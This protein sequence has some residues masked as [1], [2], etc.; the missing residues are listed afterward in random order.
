[1]FNHL[2]EI[3]AL[4]LTPGDVHDGAP[5]EQLTQDPTGK[6]FSDKGYF[7]K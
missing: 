6:L 2:N 7:G 1:M 4:K 5:V 3:V